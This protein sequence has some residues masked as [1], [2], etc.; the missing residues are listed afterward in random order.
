MSFHEQQY[1]K[2]VEVA[3]ETQAEWEIVRTGERL[4]QTVRELVD[5]RVYGWDVETSGKSVWRGARIIG[6]AF[7]WARPGRLLKSVYIPCRHEGSGELFEDLDQ[8]S[9]EIVSD[10]IRPVLE[11]PA[12]KRGAN[13][14]FDIHQAWADE[15]NV[16]PPVTDTYIGFKLTHENL[17]SYA[18]PE[19]LRIAGIPHEPGWKAVP[20]NFNRALARRW[21]MKH[22]E[23]VNLH[24]Y[25]Y[26]PIK[27]LGRYGCQDAAYEFLLG[28]WVEQ[29]QAPWADVW[30]TEMELIWA[31][32]DMERIGVPVDTTVLEEIAEQQRVIMADLEPK[33]FAAA[34][35]EFDPGNDNAVR[36]ILFN[37]LGYPDQGT[38]AK[39]TDDKPIYR[40]DDDVLWTLETQHGAPI[41]PLLRSWNA[42][43]KILSTYTTGIIDLVVNGVLHCEVDQVG[44]ATGRVSVRNPNLQNLPVRTELGRQIRKA[45]ITRPGMTRFCVDYS[46]VELR[47]LAHLSRDPLLMKI[48]QEG[49]DVHV[50]T[51]IEA[52]GTADK[53]NG[54]DMR[55]VAKTLN[56]GIPF[57]I[58]EVGVQRNINKDLPEGVKP[59]DEDRAAG[60]LHAWFKKYSGVDRWRAEHIRRVEAADN[61]EFRD[62]FGRPRR[63]PGLDYRNPRHKREAAKRQ[64]VASCVQG[65]AA[66]LVKRAMVA[67]HQY[68]KSQTHAEAYMVLMV[69]DDLHFDIASDGMSP[70]I[71][72]CVRLMEETSTLAVPIVADV[73]YL[74][75]NWATKK[76]MARR[77][78]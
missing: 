57:G 64:T 54:V 4:E 20:G 22:K 67:C 15:I 2:P 74:V 65:S 34:G 13:I 51:A 75:G 73:D 32:I 35:V 11:G 41:V 18:L 37:R 3:F 59:I 69:H 33:I 9:P 77:A 26:V 24:G 8:L 61:F 47:V 39:S 38:T 52:F 70:V 43:K 10:A 66:S 27:E 21:R 76:K 42:S 49:L 12:L 55:R 19:C 62:V 53:I 48:Y 36:D 23:L 50:T 78:A 63:M 44:A 68:L 72:E 25:K 30:A 5:Q 28:E 14:R 71:R 7:A 16:A 58:T 29:R 56:F 6:H 17:R 60:Y 40:I 31:V 45:I 46:Q 1:K